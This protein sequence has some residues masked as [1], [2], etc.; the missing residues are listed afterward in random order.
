MHPR[1][2]ARVLC[3]VAAMLAAA[4]CGTRTPHP[5][6]QP[7]AGDSRLPHIVAHRAGAGDFPE[8]TLLAIEGALRN[9]AD[10]IWLTVQLSSDGVPVLYRPADLAVNTQGAGPVAGKRFDE[11]QQLNAGW[12]FERVDE[13]GA[14][15][16]PYRALPV[17]GAGLQPLAVPSL[18]QALEAISAPLA[19]ILDMKALPAG[20]Q[21]E[22]VAR[23]LDDMHAWNR[24]LI[25]S[26]DASYQKAFARFPEAR[27]FESRDTTR[28][29]LAAVALAGECVAPPAASAW[30]AF[31]L[32]RKMELTETFTLGEA[33]S[34]VDA[35]LWTV[36]SVRCFRSR[37]HA[38]I[39]AIGVDTADDYR[40]AACLGIDAVLTDSPRK[41]RAVK[42]G[43]GAETPLRCAPR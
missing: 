35:R 24:V 13:S 29:R 3:T 42:A 9:R 14:K 10:M 38:D 2:I 23:V 25:Y 21:A 4:A 36:E 40:A 17:P 28:T 22:A 5:D 30:T 27:L 34:P 6:G 7:F 43:I 8:N 37:T 11:L 16:R 32:R 31:E 39:L 41:M 33:R 12:N 18:R 20:P 19:V 26:T 15:S 1:S